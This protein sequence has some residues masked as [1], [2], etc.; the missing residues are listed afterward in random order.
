[1]V[2]TNCQAAKYLKG[3]Y[4]QYDRRYRRFEK[5]IFTTTN[6]LDNNSEDVTVFEVDKR[7]LD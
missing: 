4:Y 2:F 7:E 3:N 1:V 5:V 6:E